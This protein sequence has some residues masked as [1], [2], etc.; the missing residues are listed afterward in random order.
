MNLRRRIPLPLI[1]AMDTVGSARRT[2]QSV[3]ELPQQRPRTRKSRNAREPNYRC[4]QKCPSI[5]FTRCANLAGIVFALTQSGPQIF[6]LLHPRDLLR[7]SWTAKILNRFLTSKSSRHVWLASFK[8]IPK[9]EEPP[10]C[11]SGMS[12]MA[13]VNLLYG[14]RC[15]VCVSAPNRLAQLSDWG[16]QN[17]ARPNPYTSAWTV[18]LRLCKTCAEEMYVLHFSHLTS[19]Y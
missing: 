19:G 1:A 15:M 14:P 4:F 9:N 7:I 6:S 12:E 3:P 16:V 17:C 10:P 13:Y 8:T 5:F 11:P 18:L 2:A